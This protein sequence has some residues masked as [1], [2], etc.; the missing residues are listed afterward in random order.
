VIQVR[1]QLSRAHRGVPASRVAPKTPAAI[2]D[3]PLVPQLV[4]LL[5]QQRRGSA[6]NAGSDRVF[7]TGRGTPF[8]HRKARPGVLGPTRR[9]AAAARFHD[10]R[11]PPDPRP[12]RRSGAVSRILGHSRV[13]ITLDVYT[14]LVGDAR[15]AAEI[16]AQMAQGAFEQFLETGSAHS[17]KL[18]ALP[19]GRAT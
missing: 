12:P 14:H 7:A 6:F 19:G 10:L 9:V 5:R 16:R 4:E 15:N 2:R 17:L 18:V 13:T 3:I 11:Q 1:A 8:G